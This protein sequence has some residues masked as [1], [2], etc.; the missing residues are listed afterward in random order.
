[1][2]ADVGVFNTLDTDVLNSNL[3]MTRTL[4]VGTRSTQ[5]T[6]VSSTTSNSNQVTVASV[7][8]IAVNDIITNTDNTDPAGITDPGAGGYPTVSSIDS[9]TITMSSA[10]TLTAAKGL[11]FTDES[12]L[13]KITNGTTLSGKGGLIQ[14][15]GDF[16][17]GNAGGAYMFFDTSAE[18]L[19]IS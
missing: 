4:K 11:T 9:N 10:Q 8:G 19:K 16:F 12:L 6:T 1:M 14:S 5:A 13:P 15:D 2:V 17:V 7:S 3:V 18:T